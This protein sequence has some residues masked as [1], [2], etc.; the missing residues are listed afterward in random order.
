MDLVAFPISISPFILTNRALILFGA[1]EWPTS[2]GHGHGNL[3][4]CFPSLPC[5][6]KRPCDQL[7]PMGLKWDRLP[8]TVLSRLKKFFL[9]FLPNSLF[10]WWSSKSSWS[11]GHSQRS[12]Q[13][14]SGPQSSVKNFFFLFWEAESCLCYIV[15][16][17]GQDQ[18]AKSQRAC[19]EISLSE[20]QLASSS[21]KCVLLLV[22]FQGQQKYIKM[23]NF[24]SKHLP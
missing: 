10:P 13:I 4:L 12:C 15:R 19:R 21:P 18:E 7:W 23:F 14:L 16:G 20:M 17:L 2:L 1:T 24:S 11:T 5:S 9:V 3:V 6:W 22:C 8:G